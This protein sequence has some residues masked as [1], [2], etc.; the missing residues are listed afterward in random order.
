MAIH[1]FYIL[2]IRNY[3]KGHLR[4]EY[5]DIDIWYEVE[6]YVFL[7]HHSQYICVIPRVCIICSLVG[8][9]GRGGGSLATYSMASPRSVSHCRFQCLPHTC[10]TR[11]VRVHRVPHRDISYTHAIPC[12]SAKRG[13]P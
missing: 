8:L 9:H 4:M 2:Y 7:F 12:Q 6:S 5:K 10:K 11:A 3:T 1:L 13:P